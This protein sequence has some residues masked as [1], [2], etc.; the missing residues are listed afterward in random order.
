[1]AQFCPEDFEEYASIEAI[2]EVADGAGGFTD[3]WVERVGVWCMVD[4][5]GGG[6]GIIAGRLEHSESLNLTTHYNSDVLDTDRVLLDGEY[7]KIT[8]IEDIDRK[9]RFMIIYLETGRT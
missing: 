3:S 9:H 1:M 8:R 2:T 6:E 5:T 4:T 7:Y